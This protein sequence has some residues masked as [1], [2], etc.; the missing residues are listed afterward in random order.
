M[1]RKKPNKF[2]DTV[3]DVPIDYALLLKIDPYTQKPTVLAAKANSV[4]TE[5]INGVYGTKQQ[6]YGDSIDNHERI[7]AIANAIKDIGDNNYYNADNVC[8]VLM[9]LKLARMQL[10]FNRDNFVD[11][12]GYTEIRHRI[13][14]HY[15]EIEDSFDGKGPAIAV[16]TKP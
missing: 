7:A 4:A 16:P 2:I 9:A 6:A 10:H 8:M 5:A 3:S 15:Q 1:S 14:E 13:K 12:I 11:L